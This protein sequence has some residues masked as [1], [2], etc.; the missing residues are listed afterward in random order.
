MGV[1]ELAQ[2]WPQ[3]YKVKSTISS[4]ILALIVASSLTVSPAAAGNPILT[5]ICLANCQVGYGARMKECPTGAFTEK[6]CKKQV[7]TVFSRCKD[8]CNK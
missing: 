8:D 5:T 4:V 3:N 2:F 1:I 6:I 7:E